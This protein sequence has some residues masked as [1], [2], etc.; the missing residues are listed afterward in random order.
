MA[1]GWRH[2]LRGFLWGIAFTLLTIAGVFHVL[3]ASGVL[4][5][6]LSWGI[7]MLVSSFLCI[8]GGVLDTVF[9]AKGIGK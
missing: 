5:N 1:T 6:E 7:Y 3:H 4:L 9:E 2:Q 8:G